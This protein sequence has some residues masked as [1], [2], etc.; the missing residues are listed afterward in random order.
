[1]DSRDAQAGSAADAHAHGHAHDPDC[2]HLRVRYR[3]CRFSGPLFLSSLK[4]TMSMYFD[5]GETIMCSPGSCVKN[6]VHLLT[7]AL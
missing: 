4:K 5:I 7:D 2:G 1:V 3:Y 6:F